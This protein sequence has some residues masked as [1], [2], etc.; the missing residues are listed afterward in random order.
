[1]LPTITDTAVLPRTKRAWAAWNY[2]IPRDESAVVQ[3]SYNMNILQNIRARHV[4]SVTLNETA[5][6]DPGRVLARFR[7][8]HPVFTRHRARAQSRHGDLIDNRDVSFCGAY[9]GYEFHEDGVRS[10]LAVCRT[11]EQRRAA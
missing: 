4:F 6:I 7:Y 11:L 5:G 3:V 10:A 1:M 2:R 8:H 9:W